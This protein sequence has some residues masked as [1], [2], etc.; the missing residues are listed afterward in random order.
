MSFLCL[1]KTI[2]ACIDVKN[3][4]FGFDFGEFHLTMFPCFHALKKQI[5]TNTE[6]SQKI[7]HHIPTTWHHFSSLSFKSILCMYC[8]YKQNY[9]CLLVFFRLP[10]SLASTR[11]CAIENY[12]FMKIMHLCYRVTS[13]ARNCLNDEVEMQSKSQAAA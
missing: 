7:I 5:S 3:R 6:K 2:C 4:F 1:F 8:H 12:A 13:S 10:I 11:Y 9:L